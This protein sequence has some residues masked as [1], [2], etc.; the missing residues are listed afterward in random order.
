[1]EP[2]S[3]NDDFLATSPVDQE[4]II[5]RAPSTNSSSMYSTE[6][7]WA[8][9]LAE[10]G[11]QSSDMLS[12]TSTHSAPSYET[13]T[14]DQHGSPTTSN[15]GSIFY[16]SPTESPSCIRNS[17]QHFYTE[18]LSTTLTCPLLCSDSSQLALP[19]KLPSQLCLYSI[20]TTHS[21]IRPYHSC[22]EDDEWSIS[23]IDFDSKATTLASTVSSQS[24]IVDLCDGPYHDPR[25]LGSLDYHSPPRHQ[26]I[27]EDAS[28]AIPP[29][30]ACLPS[31]NVDPSFF[32]SPDTTILYASPTL[33]S[34]SPLLSTETTPFSFFLFPK[35]ESSID[36]YQ[37]NSTGGAY[38]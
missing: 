26:P 30:V 35:P 9:T 24:S 34:P 36:T 1:M 18:E 29:N 14:V 31:N 7:L 22:P 20:P 2:G 38:L 25:Y 4:S 19:Q 8:K 16:T 10:M 6:R 23:S 17:I 32:T 11:L 27:R 37:D 28:R 3:S 15:R 5:Y 13:D 33:V 21:T 12:R